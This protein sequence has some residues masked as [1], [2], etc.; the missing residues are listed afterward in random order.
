[1]RSIGLLIILCVSTLSYASNR[2]GFPK[3]INYKKD[4]YRAASVNWAIAKGHKG[5]MYFANNY[6]LLAYDG[7]NWDLILESDNKTNITALSIDRNNR[8]YLGADTEFGYTITNGIGQFKYQSL[9]Q[10]LPEEDRNTGPIWHIITHNQKVYFFANRKII[11]YDGQALQVLNTNADISFA[12]KLNGTIYF[13]QRNRPLSQLK[14]DQITVIEGAE[15]SA[16]VEVKSVFSLSGKLICASANMGLFVLANESFKA[17]EVSGNEVL[18]DQKINNGLQLANKKIAIATVKGGLFLLGEDGALKTRISKEAGLQNNTIQA[19]YEDDNGYV[20]LALSNGI[21]YVELGSEFYYLDANSGFDGSVYSSA[22]F[23]ENLY[24]ATNQGL[25]RYQFNDQYQPQFEFIEQS[26]AH[27]WKLSIVEDQ[28]LLANHVGAFEVE[29]LSL[30]PLNDSNGGA[31]QFMVHPN[32]KDV[33]FQGSYEGIYV[34]R[35]INDQW[36]ITHKLAGFDETAREIAID[37]EGI[38]WVSHGYHGIYKLEV[39]QKLE[40]IETIELYDVN[41][42]LPDN[43]WN[44]LNIVQGQILIGTKQGVYAYDKASN[45]MQPDS[46]YQEILGNGMIRKLQELPN[47]NIFFIMGLDNQDDI[48]IVKNS[49]PFDIQRVPFQKLRGELIPAFESIVYHDDQLMI[50]SKDGLII[51]QP[52]VSRS[53][54]KFYTNISR[55]FLTNAGDSI[56]YGH[57]N[58]FDSASYPNNFT[59]E[60]PYQLNALRINYAASYFEVSNNVEYRTFLE[61]F[62]SD[63]SDW[64]HTTTREFTNLREGA[65]TFHVESRNIYGAVGE[66]DEFR[67]SIQPPWYRT[68][69]M[70]VVYFILGTGLLIVLITMRKNKIAKLEELRK[71]QLRQQGELH[72]QETLESERK[73]T[74]LQM[75]KLRSEVAHKSK[76]LASSAVHLAQ[77]NDTMLQVIEKIEAINTIKDKE[78][79]LQLDKVVDSLKDMIHSES[80]WDHFELHFNEIHNDFI[81]R[82]KEEFSTLTTRD[83]RL[84]AYLRM[85]LSSKE[86]AP[87][88]G[89]SYRGVESLRYRIRKKLTLDVHDNLTEFILGF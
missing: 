52:G 27:A 35:M 79:I 58:E 85:N 54:G 33:M 30:N 65:Y 26:D 67:F 21:S 60:L 70:Y 44:N 2:L 50:G 17:W 64:S 83:I 12:Q 36:K 77:Q 53:S 74:L 63:W 28:L 24:L 5:R 43:Y 40:R 81:K 10:Q 89:I 18:K 71:Q 31:W 13:Q 41:R 42:G 80:Y 76:E 59:Q 34:Y 69:Y 8:I 4:D 14:H 88:L 75:E 6:G 23:N 19:I 15:E 49:A 46:H 84:C 45:L 7:V 38:L 72:Q 47:G 56:I 78:A 86:I 32:R 37:N 68:I 62:D 48:G 9:H 25:Y 1:M 57:P 66:V 87:L 11:I 29:E 55:V 61:G 20:W 16:E 22:Y 3:V 73:L 82:L 51:Y 39:D